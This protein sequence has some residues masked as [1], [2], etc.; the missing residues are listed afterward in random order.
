[1]NPYILVSATLVVF[2]Q[3]SIAAPALI[4]LGETQ[5][6]VVRIGESR[7]SNPR[8]AQPRNPGYPDGPAGS[9]PARS[10]AASTTDLGA[11]PEQPSFTSDSSKPKPADPGEQA[12]QQRWIARAKQLLTETMARFVAPTNG[13]P[14]TITPRIGRTKTGVI[15]ALTRDSVTIDG[16]LY[17]RSQLAPDSCALLFPQDWAVPLVK[18]QV[19]KERSEQAAIARNPPP[20]NATATVRSPVAS[21]AQAGVMPDPGNLDAFAQKIGATFQFQ[22]T[23]SAAGTVW[24]TDLYT[25]D[26]P[27]A[28]A[29]VHAGILKE[30][31][32]GVVKVTLLA[33]K[34]SYRGSSQ[35]GI[36][37]SGWGPYEGSYRV[38]KVQLDRQQHHDIAAADMDDK[39]VI[40]TESAAVLKASMADPEAQAAEAATAPAETASREE[41]SSGGVLHVTETITDGKGRSLGAFDAND[42]FHEDSPAENASMTA[43]RV[44]DRKADPAIF[45]DVQN[46]RLQEVRE[47][48]SRDRTLLNAKN[49]LGRTPLCHLLSIR[50][51]SVNIGNLN[52][53]SATLTDA[54]T[55]PDTLK[56]ATFLIEAGSDLNA[57]DDEECTPLIYAITTHKADIAELLIA[58]GCN[59]TRPIPKGEYE[60]FT[61]LH[62]AVGQHQ[63]GLIPLLV[64][65]GAVPNAQTRDGSTPLHIAAK[66]DSQAEAKRLLALGADPTIRD[67]DGHT[68]LEVA[69]LAGCKRVANTITGRSE[70]VAHLVSE[71]RRLGV[72]ITA[73]AVMLIAIASALA[74]W[75]RRRKTKVPPSNASSPLDDVPSG[76]VVSETPVVAE[77]IAILTC[78]A[79]NAE[80]EGDDLFC[81]S[82]GANIE[83]RKTTPRTDPAV[84]SGSA[85]SSAPRAPSLRIRS[86]AVISKITGLLLSMGMLTIFLTWFNPRTP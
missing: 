74:F 22:V 80:N 8:L 18:A 63:A 64:A 40:E 25:L 76:L 17:P 23:G 37:S 7:A 51:M 56:M 60:G 2:V 26:S 54:E 11:T 78:R 86:V 30:G 48:V 69:Q 20:P 28:A 3:A 46:G 61:P 33:G 70:L 67:R 57:A 66:C 14:I 5:P 27:L 21:S 19:A 49:A 9:A 85:P 73:G 71:P 24:G 79:C 38:E 32:R 58:G 52:S 53:A 13:T 68:A 81:T 50:R 36:T 77:G 62:A 47:A 45:A 83:P 12:E 42:V 6:N 41:E 4:R 29:A 44:S 84:P 39:A 15:T 72:A 75:K 34:Q 55:D 43:H 31:E 10:E 59:V 82:C 65:K 35:N 16:I 1:M